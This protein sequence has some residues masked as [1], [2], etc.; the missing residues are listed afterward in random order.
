MLFLITYK[1]LCTFMII[2]LRI[3]R[4]IFQAGFVENIK[5]HVLFSVDI[6][7]ENHAFISNVGK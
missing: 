4:R 7:S 6:F 1:D 2:P 5:G 3:L